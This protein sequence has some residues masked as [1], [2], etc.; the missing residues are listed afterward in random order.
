MLLA[1]DKL[2]RD[3][4]KEAGRTAD[5]CA[6]VEHALV[7][8]GDGQAALGAR[9]SH[10]AQA[11]LLLHLLRL[12][13]G[14][15]AREQAVLRT[16]KID[17]REF[18]T[19]GR[20]H[21]HHDD[22]VRRAVILLDVG[23][24]RDLLQKA[25]EARRIRILQIRQDG[26]TQLAH[27]L[28]TGAALHIALLLEH[29]GVA[30]ADEQLVVEFRQ[31][32]RA[33]KL[34]ARLDQLRELLQLALGPLQRGIGAGIAKHGIQRAALRRALALDDLERFAADAARRLIDDAAQ[35]Q[36]V[37]T[38]V[39]EAEI[40]Q[41]VLDLRAVEEARAADDAIRDAV[42]LEGIFQRVRLRVH[43]VEHGEIAVIPAVGIRQDA[44]CDV[45]GLLHAVRGLIDAHA[46]PLPVLRP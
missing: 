20:V 43:A 39:D 24:E 8:A 11:A 2:L 7:R 38:V 19:L 36:I 16:D 23:I 1:L 17:L 26:G 22:G 3:L 30:R 6:A 4:R 29:G 13:D 46:V 15:G 32:H 21:R 41:H 31:R 34:R 25:A 40:G 45:V 5:R 10:I 33:G 28:E 27:V 44:V 37:R 14:A 35:A 9:D 18:Q 42:S 12:A